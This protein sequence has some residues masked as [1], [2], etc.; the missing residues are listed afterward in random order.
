MRGSAEHER[1]EHGTEHEPE[2]SLSRS[3]HHHCRGLNTII[4]YFLTPHAFLY[5][6][7]QKYMAFV[8]VFFLL[9]F[10]CFFLLFAQEYKNAK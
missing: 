2:I 1:A 8:F 7:N 10:V 4:D 5:F 6:R 3:Q 9:F